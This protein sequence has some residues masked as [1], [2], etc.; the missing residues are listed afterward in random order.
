[1]RYKWNYQ[2][3]THEQFEAAG[4]FS[5]ALGISPI[6]CQLLLE[7]GITDVAAARNFFHPQ[8]KE[9]HNPFLMMDMNIAVER[10]NLAMGRKERIMI[11]GDY[12]V[13]GTTAVALVYK[14]L[15]QF[16]SNIDYYIPDR[17]EEGYGVSEKGIN[18]AYETGVKLIIVLDCGIKAVKEINYAKEKG[19]DFIICDH[20]VPDEVLPPA[21]AI[22]NPKRHNATYPYPH[23]S[24]NC[25][26]ILMHVHDCCRSLVGRF[27]V[28]F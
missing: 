28:S 26:L 11:Y 3:P 5:K 14:F 6:L 16:Y 20:H 1:M 8:L 18:Y 19:I 24:G 22:L 21:V 12:D 27:P 25:L 23:L 10:L 13:D 4:T 9:L 2:T 7:R 15:Q 17:Y